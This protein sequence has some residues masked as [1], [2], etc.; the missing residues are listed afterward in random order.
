MRKGAVLVDDGIGA[1]PPDLAGGA[2]DEQREAEPALEFEAVPLGRVERD[3][4]LA[5]QRG[6]DRGEPVETAR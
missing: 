5:G 4:D 1:A 3:R 6:G 2:G